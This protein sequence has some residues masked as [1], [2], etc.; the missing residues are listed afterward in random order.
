MSA[1]F[2]V[3]P[4]WQI[5]W[6]TDGTSL[7]IAVTGSVAAW[8]Q[9]MN[10]NAADLGMNETQFSS[11]N[12]FPDEGLA[13]HR[14]RHLE[15]DV[16]QRR[17]AD[18]SHR[19]SA[20]QAEDPLRKVHL[21]SLAPKEERAVA[22]FDDRN[23]MSGEKPIH[24]LLIEEILQLELVDGQATVPA[25]GRPGL[26]TRWGAVHWAYTCTVRPTSSSSPRKAS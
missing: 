2:D 12:G 17:P 19:K 18:P 3:V 20:R 21:V 5:Q 6:Q 13:L 15:H 9:L 23:L 1:S 16:P 25:S 11:P 8:T 24:R 10:A 4:G 7:A 26:A 22:A 14:F